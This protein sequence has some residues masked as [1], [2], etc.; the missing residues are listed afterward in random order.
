MARSVTPVDGL[1][2]RVSSVHLHPVKATAALDVQVADVELWGLRH[3]RR[4]TVVGASGRR[5]NA[6]TH[7]RLLGVTATPAPAGDLVLSRH[8]AADVEVPVP[9]GGA[10]VPVDVSR[11]P[12]LMTDA[13]DVAAAWL[14]AFL[15][16][17][18]RL[19]WQHDPSLRPIRANHGGLGGEPLSL[20]DTAPLLLTTTA[21]LTRLNDWIADEHGR[22]APEMTMRRF[23]PNVVV[24]GSTVPFEED[25]WR[26]IRIG[27]VAYRF[28]EHCDRCVVTTIDPFSLA[29]DKEPLRT[30]ARH[31]RWDSKTWFG[32][33]IIPLAVG[34]L[35][36]GNRV[37]IDGGVPPATPR[38]GGD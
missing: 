6:T 35:S 30:L 26:S 19:V 31:R 33:R 22:D 10:C 15:G 25:G 9:R 13:G 7:D 37:V 24:E 34:T 8:G 29:H 1:M 11:S 36:V 32:I 3:D 38:A 5:L 16:E 14:S 17:Q 23:R 27:D 18:V 21:S 12:T 2:M 20:A 4:W 28:A